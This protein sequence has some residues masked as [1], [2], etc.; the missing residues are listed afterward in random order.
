MLM[1]VGG[2]G[3][4]VAERED[5]VVVVVG[6]G[7]VDRGKGI[8]GLGMSRACP[9][10]RRLSDTNGQHSVDGHPQQCPGKLDA[11]HTSALLFSDA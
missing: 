1:V 9:G 2:T 7:W 11:L 10:C 4:R 3:S 6:W 5:M 8:R